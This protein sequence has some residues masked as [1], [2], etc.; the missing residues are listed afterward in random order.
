MI[1]IIIS[2]SLLV[3]KNMRSESNMKQSELRGLEILMQQENEFQRFTVS[4]IV[5]MLS[6]SFNYNIYVY[7]KKKKKK[8]SVFK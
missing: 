1:N 7:A 8:N 6:F 3:V 2:R 5:L 4:V